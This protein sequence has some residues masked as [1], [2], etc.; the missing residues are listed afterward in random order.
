MA[1][2][3]TSLSDTLG[4]D[5]RLSRL[6]REKLAVELVKASRPMTAAERHAQSWGKESFGDSFKKGSSAIERAQE[7]WKRQR[8]AS[9]RT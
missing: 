7:D 1:G 5:P 9:K 8:E 3:A 4:G 2:P 6:E